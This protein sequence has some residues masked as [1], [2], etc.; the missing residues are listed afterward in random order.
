[1]NKNPYDI[2]GISENPIWGKKFKFRVRSRNTGKLV[3]I[4]VDFVLE[5]KETEEDF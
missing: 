4:N 1:M 3:D 2:L 5:K